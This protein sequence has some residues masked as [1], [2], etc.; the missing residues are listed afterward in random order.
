L[1]ELCIDIAN[2]KAPEGHNIGN[3]LTTNL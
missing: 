1:N 3:H 2:F